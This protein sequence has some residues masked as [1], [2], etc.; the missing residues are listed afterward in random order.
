[1]NDIRGLGTAVNVQAMVFG[2]SGDNSA[3]GVAVTRDPSTGEHKYFYGEYL[4]NAQGEDVVAGIRTPQQ[5]TIK[6]SREWA[7]ACSVSE[8]VRKA[9]Y[10]SLEEVMP[11]VFK[12][13]DAI[14]VKLERHYR[15][16]Q[17][18]EFTIEDGTLY[19]LQTR[20][21]KRTAAAAVKIATISSRRSSSTRRLSDARRACAARSVLHPFS[22]RPPR[23]RP[24]G[25][26]SVCRLRR[27]R[28]P[29]RS[30]STRPRPSSGP[31]MA[32]RS[33]SAASRP[34]PRI[35]AA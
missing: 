33:F 21:G 6:G 14:R 34:A 17:D 20:N 30:F 1:M 29:A 4:I 22:S 15:D 24:S 32:R 12:Q 18:L 16:M 8:A 27:A 28:P 26:R 25:L 5:I 19:M 9:Q 3:T 10:P 11:K 2:N 13:L 23:P 35:S 31:R 7:K